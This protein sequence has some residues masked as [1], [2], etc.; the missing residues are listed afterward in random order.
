MLDNHD[1]LEDIYRLIDSAIADD[2]PLSPKDNGIIK[3]GYNA[4]IDEL[5]KLSGSAKQM[6]LDLEARERERTGIK[7]L[8]VGYNKVFGYYIEISK[9]RIN[10]APADYIRKQT[11][12]NGER[13]ITEEL[14]ELEAKMLTAVSVCLP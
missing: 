2:A 8:K 5:R 10:E 12:V 3:T 14:K 13:F 4:E 1:L 11:L 9:S 6:L 7:T